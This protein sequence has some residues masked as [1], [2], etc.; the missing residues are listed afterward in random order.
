[1]TLVKQVR[2]AVYLGALISCNGRASREL[3]RRLGE[4]RAVFRT[5]CKVWSHSGICRQRKAHIY[6]TCVI[7]KVLYSLDSVWLV[8]TERARLDAFH[9][10]CLRTIWGIAPSYY[11][12]VSNEEVLH[13]SGQTRLSIQLESRQASLY[14]RIAQLSDE[15]LVKALVCNNDGEPLSWS[16]R[17]RRGRPRQMWAHSVFRLVQEASNEVSGVN[18]QGLFLIEG[19]P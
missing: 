7:T 6:N 8:K 15:S 18:D 9:C 4:G 10:A 2:E 16:T 1:M 3:S 14:R 13:R 12:R 5:L 19:G 17:R 11:S